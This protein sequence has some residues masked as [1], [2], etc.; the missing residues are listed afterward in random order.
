LVLIVIGVPINPIVQSRTRYYW[1]CKPL[2]RDNII[3]KPKWTTYIPLYSDSNINY[4]NCTF[5]VLSPESHAVCS[6]SYL[7]F[8]IQKFYPTTQFGQGLDPIPQTTTTT[9][10]LCH[11][12]VKEAQNLKKKKHS[13]QVVGNSQLNC[14]VMLNKRFKTMS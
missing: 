4:F 6:H 8:D 5:P 3:P 12:L 7:H 13:S 9:T 1:S 2:I 11:T 14:I 10:T